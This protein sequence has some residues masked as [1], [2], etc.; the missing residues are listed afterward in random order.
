M[1]GYESLSVEMQNILLYQAT[2]LIKIILLIFLISIC[3]FYTRQFKKSQ[4]SVF[5]LAGTFRHI[6]NL[7][8]Y[9][10]LWCSP[11]FILFLSPTVSLD[12]FIKV[13]TLFYTLVLFGFFIVTTIGI[14][15]YGIGFFSDLLGFDKQYSDVTKEVT[16]STYGK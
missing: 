9:V 11:L 3:Y 4:K 15:Y 6:L 2:F 13:L 8:S 16:N 5:P 12:L 7:V 10:V 14:M 1:A